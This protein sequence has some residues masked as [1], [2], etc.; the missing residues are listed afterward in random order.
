[1]LTPF[2][3]LAAIVFQRQAPGLGFGFLSLFAL[4]LYLLTSCYSL[5]SIQVKENL[6]PHVKR[7]GNSESFLAVV[8]HS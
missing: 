1:M 2:I 3:A 7:N 6:L 5:I 4:T 8:M